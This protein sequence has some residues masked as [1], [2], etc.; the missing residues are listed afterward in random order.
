MLE[1]PLFLTI[2]LAAGDANA[3]I[4]ENCDVSGGVGSVVAAAANAAESVAAAAATAAAP[5]PILLLLP[6]PLPPL[7][8]TFRTSAIIAITAFRSL[9]FVLW[10]Y[11]RGTPLVSR[12][13]Y[14]VDKS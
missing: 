9:T 14:R 13:I 11:T 12:Y 7:L 10:K 2:T 5:P 6:L 3:P 4:V 1:N 8:C